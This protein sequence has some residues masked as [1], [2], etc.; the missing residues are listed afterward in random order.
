MLVF[1][2]LAVFPSM[3]AEYN[4]KDLRVVLVLLQHNIQKN[5]K[6]DVA[7]QRSGVVRGCSWKASGSLH[8]NM[9]KGG[10]CAGASEVSS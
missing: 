1:L 10:P 6:V 7:V 3:A 5:C 2:G 4:G 9:K 8:D